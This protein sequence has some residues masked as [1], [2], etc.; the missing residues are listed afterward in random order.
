[1]FLSDQGRDALIVRKIATF[2]NL[3]LIGAPSSVGQVYLGPFYYY[4]IT[5]FLPLFNWNPVGLAFGVALIAIVGT[6]LA[7]QVIKTKFGAEIGITFL[8][9]SVFSFTLIHFSR[10]SWNPNP[11][12]YFG[13][14]SLFFLYRWL[15]EPRV[16]DGLLFGIM[17]GLTIQLHYLAVLLFVPVIIFFVSEMIHNKNRLLYLFHLPIPVTAFVAAISPLV[18]FDIRHDFLNYRQLIKLFT[19]G[20]LSTEASYMDRLGETIQGFIASAVQIELPLTTATALFLLFIVAAILGTKKIKSR[21]FAIQIVAVLTYIIGFA[22]LGSPR[23][24]HYYGPIFLSFFFVL[25]TLPFLIKRKDL[26]MMAASALVFIFIYFNISKYYF[27]TSEPNH[28]VEHSKKVATFLYE[29]IGN[30]PFNIATWPVDFGEDTYLYFLETMGAR[31]A[32]RSQLE[33]TEQMFVICAQEPCLVI[34][35]PSWNISMFGDAKIAE[36][37]DIEGLKIYKLVHRKPL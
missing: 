25:G 7:Y 8:I 14:F 20:G 15:K 6:L 11:L 12:P 21:L 37:W 18:L 36:E 33:I 19:E 24:A 28:Q 16:L 2:E 1:M 29:Q 27:F 17:F 9:L 3:P 30:K 4:L 5:P 34:D 23:H 26:A 13:F 10:F 22:Y 32:D 35:S 31:A